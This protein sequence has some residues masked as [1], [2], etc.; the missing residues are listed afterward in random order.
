[1]LRF[2]PIAFILCLVA[3]CAAPESGG[4]VGPGFTDDEPIDAGER[5][6]TDRGTPIGNSEPDGGEGI[7]PPNADAGSPSNGFDGGRGLGDAGFDGEDLGLDN[8]GGGFGGECDV[9]HPTMV[10]IG[11]GNPFLPFED[12]GLISLYLGTAGGAMV[13]FDVRTDGLAEDTTSVAE[14]RW[15]FDA[16][17]I[18]RLTS[19]GEAECEEEAWVIRRVGIAISAA[20]DPFSLI[21]QQVDLRI[22]FTS[23]SE[24]GEQSTITELGAT[25]ELATD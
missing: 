20:V 6:P 13:S 12:G 15:D 25:L 23:T 19:V 2:G 1:M 22:E 24:D 8:G 7:P 4:I 9:A 16:E 10:E 18:G 21:G 11:R 3:A 14:L 5:D 17:P